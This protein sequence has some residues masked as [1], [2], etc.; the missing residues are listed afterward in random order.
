MVDQ[1]DSLYIQLLRNFDE[2][3]SII[4]EKSRTFSRKNAKDKNAKDIFIRFNCS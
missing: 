4:D 1:L 3:I 2:N